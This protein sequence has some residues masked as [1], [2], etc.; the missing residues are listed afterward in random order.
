MLFKTKI[1]TAG[2]LLI[3][4]WATAQYSISG[5][6]HD[7]E[8][9][10][11]MPGASI[12]LPQIQKGVFSDENGEYEIK[13]L[14]PG[15]YLVRVEYDGYEPQNRRIHV[16]KDERLD[17]EMKFSVTELGEV[18]ITGV[19][20]ATELKKSPIVLRTL[21]GQD[22]MRTPSAN[23]VSALQ[24]V[25]GIAEIS[26]GSAISKPV[27]RGLGFNRVVVLN[28]GIRQ[29]EQQW[30]DEHG[31]GLDEF[32]V[33]RVE[34][35]KGPG[36]LMYGSDAMAGVINFIAPRPLPEGELDWQ[37]QSQYQTNDRRMAYSLYNAGNINGWQWSGRVSAKWA[38]DYKNRYD[39]RVFNS[40][41]KEWDAAAFLG[42]NRNWGFSRL[43]LKSYNTNLGIVEGERDEE[44][45]FVYENREGEE[46]SFPRNHFRGYKTSVPYQK[47]H[48]LS[49]VS[50]TRILMEP[51]N[52]N[53]DLGYQYNIRKEFEEAEAPDEAGL[54]LDLGTFT[55]NFTY[56]FRKTNGW[57]IS[58]GLGGMLQ[59]NKNKG[60]E[61]LIPDYRLWDTGIFGIVQKSFGKLN[62]AGGLRFDFRH[63]NS[64]ALDEDGEPKFIAFSKNFRG[65]AGSAG[66]S[67]ELDEL[68]VL[69]L[70]FSRGY[71]APN[72]AELGSNGVHEGTFRYEI[73]NSN[74]KPEVSHQID[75]AYSL[76]SE[77]LT[78]ELT[79]FVNFIRHYI[80]LEKMEEDGGEVFPDPDDP[81]PGYRFT[82][83]NARLTGVEIYTDL[84]PHPWDW[85]HLENSF[86]IVRGIQK[87]R[88]ADE[89]YL[90]QMP[91]SKYRGEIKTEFKK[92]GKTLS[93]FYFRIGL[94]HYFK[95][96]RVFSAFDTET[97]S[98]GYTLFSAGI[99]TDIRLK[100]MKNFLSLHIAGE[101]L[102]NKAYQNSLSRLKY[103]PMNPKT[104]RRGVYN[105]GRN[106]SLKL[107][108]NF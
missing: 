9:D 50:H 88:P 63:L 24:S 94:E 19:T 31:V 107:V 38:G 32:S 91:A 85:L 7:A 99:G 65:I 108:M 49:A 64:K 39:G 22:L 3:S 20:R 83:G 102:G 15:E 78:L 16:Q 59:N 52:L 54:H 89:R 53:I 1:I 35:I 36:S 71:R 40:A 74:L 41:S 34:I 43:T 25:P 55:Y 104:G 56:D 5:R 70:N 8:F 47:V 79:P 76:N 73:G 98:A 92:I 26:T 77:H 23:P 4:A 6:I 93:H 100:G 37:L 66:I 45:N 18:I 90:P 57:E 12:Y 61:F 17:F 21:S 69:K 14:K 97:P 46:I 62:F 60:D 33:D 28:D 72:M 75:L 29:E 68:S 96:D 42:L 87:N 106:I 101:N 51:G 10:E 58:A 81:V 48:H 2:L 80:Y 103:A 13:D 84:H 27:I 30:G 67:Y 44:G 82:S 11:V 86:S 95:Q 105:P